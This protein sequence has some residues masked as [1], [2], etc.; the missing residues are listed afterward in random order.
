MFTKPTTIYRP[1]LREAWRLTR[2]RKSL[3]VFG[4]FA[5]LISTGGVVDI[6]AS[7]FK[8]IEQQGSLLARFMD[9]SFIGYDLATQYIRQLHVLGP[10]RVMGLIIFAT[11]TGLALLVMATISQGALIA[12]L[13]VKKPQ[14][15]YAL[16]TQASAHFWPLLVLAVLNKIVTSIFIL[17]VTLPLFLFYVSTNMASASLFFLLTLIFIPAITIV[18]II[19]MFALIDVVHGSNHP[20]DAI[21]RAFHL[22]TRH[23]LSMLEY[24]LLLFFL[25][26]GAGVIALG[27]L[28][29]LSVPYA[30]IFTASFFTGS[31]SFFLTANV[32]FGLL[33][34]IAF[35]LF[36]GAT[37]TFQY[38]AWYQFYLHGMHKTHGKKIF[39][40][41]LR[42]AY[43]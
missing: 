16:K 26:F 20:L 31:F 23:W 1:L 12:G 40:K 10:D 38:S 6:V 14:E 7:S 43:R 4:I 18:N 9:S 39:S 3:W 19:Y 42:L 28:A 29:L 11:I 35:L 36:A 37:I 5:G 30:I 25:V 21:Q 33:L 22:F 15:P 41:L 2:E 8:K 17:L 27:L 34:V 24:G 32:I 13:K